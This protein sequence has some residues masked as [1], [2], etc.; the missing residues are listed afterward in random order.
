MIIIKKKYLYILSKCWEV[1]EVET[2]EEA[3]MP[4]VKE[5]AR[6]ETREEVDSKTETREEAR[7]EVK[8]EVEA[9]TETR[10]EVEVR[11]EAREEVREDSSRTDP[12]PREELETRDR[13]VDLL[14]VVL[15]SP[16][17]TN[18]F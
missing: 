15:E 10:E 5:E 17:R 7:T 11:T 1:P 2:L 3:E 18:S 8:E 13:E 6:T 9:R 12:E 4:E 14:E 16:R